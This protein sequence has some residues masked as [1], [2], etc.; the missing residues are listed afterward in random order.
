[1]STKILALDIETM[2]A[3]VYTFSLFKPVIGHNQI[4]EPSRII[5]FSAQ[6]RGDKKVQF[7][8]EHTH[9]RSEM[10]AKLHEL[11]DEAD[12]VLHYNGASFDMPWIYGELMLE[13]FDPPSPTRNIDMYQFMKRNTRLVSRK[14]DYVVERF[15]DEHKVTHSGFKLWRDCDAGDEK[16]WKQMEKY[17]IK[18][19]KLLLPLYEKIKGWIPNHPNV[20]LIDGEELACTRCSSKKFQ[21]RGYRHTNASTFRQYQCKDCGGWFRSAHRVGTNIV[22]N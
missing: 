11:L 8:S 20:A 18:D 17:A 21:R 6:W 14:L 19:T 16:A 13:G 3:K 2:A 4:I 7:Y 12:L 10:L 5:C 9:G 1:M 22:R 15:L